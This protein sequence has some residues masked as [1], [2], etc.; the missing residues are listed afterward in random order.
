[1]SNRNNS[2]QAVY[3]R[4]IAAGWSPE[5]AAY[6]AIELSGIWPKSLG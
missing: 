3:A 2:Y 1:M 5:A 4:L 6:R